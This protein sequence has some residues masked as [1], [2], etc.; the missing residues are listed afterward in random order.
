M[1]PVLALVGCTGSSETGLAEAQ[2]RYLKAK[3]ACDRDHPD[4][5]ATR[6]D[7]RTHAANA[8]IRPYYRY[9]DLMTYVQDRRKAL[10]V[11]VDQHQL[12]R[13]SYD[14]RVAEAERKVSKEEDRRNRLAHVD[15]SYQSTPF[16]PVAKTFAR[17][18]N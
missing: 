3:A 16:T 2:H 15:S 12:S 4:S 11:Q 13:R 9:G 6:A 10:A 14:L 5:L 18:F 7:C 1:L 8:F 17:I